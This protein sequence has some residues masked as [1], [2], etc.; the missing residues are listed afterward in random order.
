MT[1]ASPATL[2]VSALGTPED[3]LTGFESPL[4]SNLAN[5]PSRIDLQMRSLT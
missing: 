5:Y 1:K 3:N 2:L 4:G